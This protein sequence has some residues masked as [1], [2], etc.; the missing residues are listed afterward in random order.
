M[1]YIR[2][3]CTAGRVVEVYEYHT[4]RYP[5]KGENRAPRK[6]ETQPAQ[7]EVNR[8]NAERRLR[9]LVNANFIPGDHHIT[10]TYRKGE[11]PTPQEA[12][13]H[14]AR[15]LRRLR[16]EYRREGTELKYICVTEWRNASIHHHMILN[17]HDVRRLQTLWPHGRIHVSPL[18]D[19]GQYA[20]LAE[21]LVKETGHKGA[22]PKGAKRWR[23]SKNL[24]QPVIKQRVMMAA[25]WGK[26]PK[27][28]AGYA[29]EKDSARNGWHE[30]TGWPWRFYSMRR[31]N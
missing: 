14:L 26:E 13:N 5:G 3:T 6:K 28:M 23:A 18:D 10:L 16:D 7:E 19:T 12:E 31:M 22:L 11:R 29:L 2:E 4:R 21:Y 15:Y 9:R 20:K 24:K 30:L 8:R 27:P 25:T 17:Y 1:P